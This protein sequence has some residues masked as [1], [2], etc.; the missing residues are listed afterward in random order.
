M[1]HNIFPSKKTLSE[2]MLTKQKITIDYREKNSLVPPELIN[3]GMDI[4]FKQLKVA[5]YLVRETAIERKTPL[6]FIQSIID[7]R[8]F[9][10]LKEIKQYPNHLLIIEGEFK[11]TQMHPNAIRGF[12]LSVNLNYKIPIIFTKDEKDTATYLTLLAK[13]QSKPL[14]LNPTKS[15]LS[16]NER[17]Q[18][19][20]ESFPNI[21]PIKSK[22]LLNKFK[23]IKK[24]F[25]SNEQELKKILGNRVWG[26]LKIINQVYSSQ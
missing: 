8:L 11:K 21:G 22:Q 25:D 26:F 19:I 1:I 12:I 5:D 4:E 3:Q 18:Y 16:Q 15:N 20:L 23:T 10:Q 6:D 2:K 17:L 14:S 7:K 13:K 24:I 9:N